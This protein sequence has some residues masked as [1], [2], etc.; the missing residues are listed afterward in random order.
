MNGDR[1]AL[2]RQVHLRREG[3]QVCISQHCLRRVVQQVRPTALGEADIHDPA[4]GIDSELQHDRPL[5]PEPPRG[6]RIGTMSRQ[7][8]TDVGQ[9]VSA[10][11]CL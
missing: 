6:L 11:V 9:P 10:W 2:T 5:P 3:W 1:E 7:P 8:G 4:L